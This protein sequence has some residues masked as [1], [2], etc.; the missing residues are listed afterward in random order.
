MKVGK[1]DH[2]RLV[3]RG[4]MGDQETILKCYRCGT[5]DTLLGPNI[6][7]SIEMFSKFCEAFAEGHAECEGAEIQAPAPKTPAEWLN[8]DDT[9]V[10]SKTIYSVM[11]GIHVRGRDADVP[12]DPADFGRCHRL[13]KLFP[14]WRARLGEV[15]AWHPRWRGL[16]DAW[17]ELEALYEQELPAGT[18]PRLYA[19]M[20]QLIEGT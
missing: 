12:H 20:R 1:S 19:R 7:R 13:L 2:V 17:A 10:S 11:M 18:A 4:G 9:G 14:E 3:T 6:K 16:V 8:G 5:E 15:A